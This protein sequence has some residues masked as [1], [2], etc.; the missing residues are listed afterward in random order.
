VIKHFSTEAMILLVF[1]T[2]AY[3]SVFFWDILLIR[4]N[5]MNNKFIC[6]HKVKAIFLIL[7]MLLI[8]SSTSLYAVET[9]PIIIFQKVVHLSDQQTALI[10]SS[11]YGT[12]MSIENSYNNTH[13]NS[14]MSKISS[15]PKCS[16]YV[17]T[18]METSGPSPSGTSTISG[19]PAEYTATNTLT[20]TTENCGALDTNTQASAGSPFFVTWSCP[21]GFSAQGQIN[22]VSCVKPERTN[23]Q[24][25]KE[26]NPI[27]YISGDKFQLETDYSGRNGLTIDRNYLN[28]RQSWQI[29]S[30]GRLFDF[31]NRYIPNL[32]GNQ[33]ICSGYVAYFGLNQ[34][35]LST[36]DPTDVIKIPTAFCL[37]FISN[38]IQPNKVVVR[39]KDGITWDLYSKGSYYGDSLFPAKLYPIDPVANSGA[40]WKLLYN[41][42]KNDF[43]DANGLLKKTVYVS[44]DEI[45]YTYDNE[46]LMSK[47]NRLGDVVSFAYDTAGRI[48]SAQV[49]GGKTIKY[50]YKIAANT[51]NISL[52]DSVEALDGAK[53]TYEYADTRFPFALT[54]VVD[55][56]G[57]HYASWSYDANG[58][59]I[60]SQ[61][62]DGAE[63]FSFDY[64]FGDRTTVTNPL[65]KKTTY[66]FSVING[67]K[68]ITSVTGVPTTNCVGANKNYTYTPEGWL[69]SK[70]DWNGN[71]TVYAY[72]AAGQEISRTEANGTP[73]AKTITTEW[74]PTLN[75]KTKITEPNKETTFS[76][77]ANGLLLNKNTRS[78]P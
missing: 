10:Q 31:T 69:A 17:C 77:D 63:L 24:C 28:Q 41:D 54:G 29:E 25:T 33:G 52:L 59:A 62:A 74:H 47:S 23:N 35:N 9:K 49:P 76:Y 7:N 19:E 56:N 50:N 8:L 75:I 18:K 21:D 34:P 58:K 16:H 30:V 71:K 67:R 44:G 12:L 20:T 57:K 64:T 32:E 6:K 13:Y 53:T 14:C 45:N 15:G 51:V 3:F 22:T 36:P 42:N 4:S 2:A 5:K 43:F 11:E 38:S 55:A 40:A 65:G 68:L 1:Q 37:R 61:H 48:I 66:N 26:G 39:T 27:N 70:T 72:N 78:L 46:K 60:S 73:L